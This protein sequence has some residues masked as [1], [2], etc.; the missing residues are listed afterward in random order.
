MIIF[1]ILFAS[2]ISSQAQ[3]IVFISPE[4]PSLTEQFDTAV[5][6]WIAELAKQDEFSDWRSSSIKWNRQSLGPGMH[7]WI[8]TVSDHQHELG[9]LVVTA[10]PKN[11]FYLTEYGHGE[12][13]LFSERTLYRSLVQHELIDSSLSYKQFLTNKHMTH[14]R[15]YV[16]P[17][18][19]IWLFTDGDESFQLDA[20]TGDLMT[21]D[22][23]LLD[24]I[25]KSDA[26]NRSWTATIDNTVHVEQSV[27]LPATDPFEHLGWIVRPPSTIK[28]LQQ[29][30]ASLNSGQSL[31]FV[32]DL[33]EDT[34]VYALSVTGY[35][36]WN[37]GDPFISID[38][39]G[40]RFIPAQLMMDTGLY[41]QS[42]NY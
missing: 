34:V 28:S 21:I 32:A 22:N 24:R 9:Y 5:N 27:H 20:K 26:D 7:G 40:T 15:I 38:Q 14:Q 41:Y 4:Q 35:H 33:Y 30:Q 12:Y 13:P 37:S 42:D 6:E 17:L 2:I 29:V 10:D 31:T 36:Q 1:L 23:K 18:Q 3:Q 19:T 11:I 8:V 25:M 39:D 16:S